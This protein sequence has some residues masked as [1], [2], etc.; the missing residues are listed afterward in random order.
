M[1]GSLLLRA[2]NVLELLAECPHGLPLQDIADRLE[3]F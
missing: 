1:A 3:M 2:T